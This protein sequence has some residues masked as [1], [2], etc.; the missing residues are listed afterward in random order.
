VFAFGVGI[1]S[2]IAQAYNDK[3]TFYITDSLDAQRLYNAATSRSR[4]GSSPTPRG[5]TASSCSS[6]TRWD[7]GPPI[8]RSSGS[9]A[10]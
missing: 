3:S 1:G 6:A 8:C 4:R 5:P 9:L 10:S 2:M 7:R